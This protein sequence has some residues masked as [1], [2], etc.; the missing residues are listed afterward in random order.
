[1]SESGHVYAIGVNRE[2]HIGEMIGLHDFCDVTISLV[3]LQGRCTLSAMV[4][5][6]AQVFTA[7]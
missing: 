3:F 6:L 7:P 1:M 2:D 5:D 4:I